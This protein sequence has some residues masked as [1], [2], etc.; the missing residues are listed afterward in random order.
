MRYGLYLD[1]PT[2]ARCAMRRPALAA[3]YA[4]TPSR[5][6]AAREGQTG[7]FWGAAVARQPRVGIDA[8][9]RSRFKIAMRARRGARSGAKERAGKLATPRRRWPPL[10]N[11]AHFAPLSQSFRFSPLQY[12]PFASR[13]V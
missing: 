6:R 1:E 7:N 13:G 5:R 9:E 12:A 4:A 2:E 8:S 10:L 11:E 3:A